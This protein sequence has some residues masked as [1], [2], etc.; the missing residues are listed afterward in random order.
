MGKK[1]DLMTVEERPMECILCLHSAGYHAM[2]PLYDTCGKEG[3]Q[4]VLKATK[5]G[6]GGNQE[7]GMGSYVMCT[8]VDSDQGI[9]VWIGGQKYKVGTNIYKEFP[10]EQ[11]GYHRFFKGEVKRFDT[12]RKF[13]KIV[14]EDGDKEEMTESQVKKYL[15]NPT[16]A[17]TTKKAQSL[18]LWL[19]EIFVSMRK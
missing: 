6:I 7:V 8:N 14:Y 3:R 16:N 18:L 2:H 15:Q 1:R 10:D 4:Y 13:Y 9:F 5:S 19:H 17:A 12:K 11:T